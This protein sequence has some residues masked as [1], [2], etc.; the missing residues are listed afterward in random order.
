M[1]KPSSGPAKCIPHLSQNTQNLQMSC[2]QNH[3]NKKMWCRNLVVPLNLSS[4]HF[5]Y[6][7]RPKQPSWPFLGG[8]VLGA[9]HPQRHVPRRKSLVIDLGAEK[10]NNEAR[11]RGRSR[12]RGVPREPPVKVVTPTSL[13][14]IKIRKKGYRN[15]YPQLDIQ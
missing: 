12:C 14:T 5:P 1:S 15:L 13:G 10:V 11:P 6:E 3:I 8:M 9:A 7:I 4:T 2:A